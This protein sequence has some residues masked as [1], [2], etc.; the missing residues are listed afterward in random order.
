MLSC[1]SRSLRRSTSRID[2]G[3]PGPV[4]RTIESPGYRSFA[5]KLP[6]RSQYS[7]RPPPGSSPRFGPAANSISAR[8]PA[9]LS[10]WTEPAIR[11]VASEPR[12]PAPSAR[13]VTS[14]R[15]RSR[16]TSSGKATVVAACSGSAAGTSRWIRGFSRPSCAGASL[17]EG[18]PGSGGVTTCGAAGGAVVPISHHA[19]PA[20]PA[21]S[22]KT[23]R[24]RRLRCEE[25]I[26]R[27]R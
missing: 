11:A 1:V 6:L 5:P 14:A 18:G 7:R 13:G 8:T 21:A 20:S 19:P 3:I 15:A 23:R 26:R 16:S 10:P 9:P 4:M 27:R 24:M 25:V 17:G 22:T 12:S 2:P